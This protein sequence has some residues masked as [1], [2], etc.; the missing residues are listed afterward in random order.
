MSSYEK[1]QSDRLFKS[2]HLFIIGAINGLYF[3]FYTRT[4]LRLCVYTSSVC[5]WSNCKSKHF[6][7]L[8]IMCVTNMVIYQTHIAIIHH[9]YNYLVCFLFSTIFYIFAKLISDNNIASTLHILIHIVYNI[10]NI[11]LD[12]T[13]QTFN[14]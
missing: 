3:K 6:K 13:I 4:F 1:K 7:K 14:C 8:D 9:N 10:A 12:F 5:Y 2:S 11:Y